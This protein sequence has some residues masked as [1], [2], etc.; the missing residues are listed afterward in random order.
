MLYV[1][2]SMLKSTKAFV[3]TPLT[4]EKSLILEAFTTSSR[5]LILRGIQEF[6]GM[7]TDKTRNWMIISLQ[8]PQ[9]LIGGRLLRK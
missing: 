7:E 6:S 4:P 1:E 3:L 2:F 9:S 8:I 5:K